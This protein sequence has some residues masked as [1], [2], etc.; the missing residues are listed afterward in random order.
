SAWERYSASD[1]ELLKKGIVRAGLDELALYIAKG[2][3]AFTWKT[4]LSN[5]N[6]TVLLH[7]NQADVDEV[8][9]A[10]YACNGTLEAVVPVDPTL[11][12]WR[13]ASVA[14]RI[15]EKRTYF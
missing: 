5:G 10:A 1:K 11:P 15:Q 8:D 2:R 4:Q 13:L 3:P 7:S 14:P 9:T 12:C 6:C